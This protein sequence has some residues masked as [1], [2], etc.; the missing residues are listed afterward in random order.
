M[1][2]VYDVYVWKYGRLEWTVHDIVAND[3]GQAA[4][5]AVSALRSRPDLRN[6][7][8]LDALSSHFYVNS[9]CPEG[10][11]VQVAKRVDRPAQA[12]VVVS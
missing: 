2:A 10:V 6:E 5:R 1:T 8:T 9:Q 7:P 11:T 12:C 3:N 4:I